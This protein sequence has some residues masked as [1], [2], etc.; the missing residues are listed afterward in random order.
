MLVSGNYFSGFGAAPL[1]GRSIVPEDDRP[2]AAPVAMITYRGWE[3]FCGLD[4]QVIGQVVSIN[5]STFT[6][7]G[8][9]PRSYMGPMAGD[10]AD[11]YLPLS[12]QAQI[13]PTQQPNSPDRWWLQLMGRLA[14]GADGAQ[15]QASLAV[16]FR[17]ALSLSKTKMEQGGIQL[18]D[19]SRGQLMLRRALAKP[20]L[21]LTAVVGVVLLVACANVAGLLLARGAARRHEMAVRAAIGA[22]RWRLIGQSLIESLVLS[23]GGAALGLVVAVWSKRALLGLLAGQ[24]EGWRFDLHT[25]GRV[26][27]F[28]LGVSLSAALIFGILPAVHAARANPAQSLRNRSAVGAPRLG[29]GKAL[30][31]GQ[32][33][34][35]VLL[36]GRG[37]PH[38]PHV[39]QPGAH[40]AGLR[41]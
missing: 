37:R 23:L 14:P 21:V 24:P 40:P 27:A 35:S 7:I 38:G 29:L 4:P 34:L 16:P 10:S 6:L 25:D 13:W 33:A 5:K 17:Q 18:E 19:G 3:R 1:I 9:L 20:Y 22:G 8:V 36:A 32:V 39:R 41:S 2:G 26:L 28:T 11:I 15:A 30:V 31:A 12:T